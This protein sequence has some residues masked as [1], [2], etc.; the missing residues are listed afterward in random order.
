[1]RYFAEVSGPITPPISKSCANNFHLK[2]PS[3][4]LV[5]STRTNHTRSWY[6]ANILF[7]SFLRAKW[8]GVCYW[9]VFGTSESLQRHCFAR[10]AGKASSSNLWHCVGSLGAWVKGG[11]TIW[12][13][14]PGNKTQQFE[15]K[16]EHNKSILWLMI[17]TNHASLVRDALYCFQYFTGAYNPS[18]ARKSTE[19]FIVCKFDRLYNH[20]NCSTN[21]Q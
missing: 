1:M 18:Y 13:L 3:H 12:C 11:T 21:L 15:M 17:E 19:E 20:T 2:R 16:R 7:T 10:D 5:H 14:P 8:L 9:S 4:Y 6:V